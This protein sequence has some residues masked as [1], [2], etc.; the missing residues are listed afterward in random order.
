MV[1]KITESV[2]DATLQKDLQRYEHIAVELG[3]T[4]AK[5]ITTDM[6][7]IDE[8]VRAKCIFPKCEWYGTNAHCPPH[9]ISLDDARKLVNS[10]KY[11]VFFRI[12]ASVETLTRHNTPEQQAKGLVLRKNRAEIVA[13]LEAEAFYD[14]Y[15]LAVGFSGG[16]CKVMFC[17]N[18]DC[19][20][21]KGSPC[22]AAF[23]ARAAM[24]A[25][26]MDVFKLAT[27]V[28][29]D[30]YPIGYKRAEAPHLSLFGLVLIY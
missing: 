9:A 8:R 21:L 1:H 3:A 16:G 10:F 20:V 25:V 4:E 29:W 15:Y 19:A 7:T 13:K 18:D 14:G 11:A 2:L 24:E 22:R 28:G 26:G 27:R 30:I 23:R 12:K 5:I 6:I 17:P